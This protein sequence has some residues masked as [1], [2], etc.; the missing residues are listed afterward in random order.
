MFRNTA[1]IVDAGSILFLNQ[2]AGSY[3]GKLSKL[4]LTMVFF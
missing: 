2:N 1:I 3:H 4:G